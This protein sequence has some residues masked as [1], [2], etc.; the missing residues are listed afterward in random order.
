[1]QRR[2]TLRNSLKHLLSSEQI[3]AVGI[4]AGIRAEMLTIEEFVA[5]S[6]Q[7]P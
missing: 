6:D 4:D 5:L 2:K 7:L 3:A 1:M